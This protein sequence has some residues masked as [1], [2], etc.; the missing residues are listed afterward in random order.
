MD[1]SL[2]QVRAFLTVARV[3]S[4]TQAA[5]ILNVTQPA[6]T[7]QIRR[8]EETLGVKLFDRDTRTV[9]L[10]RVARDL[11]PLF[12]RT[13]QD[14]EAAIGSARD[15]ASQARGVV[16]LAVLPS[17]AAG[18]LPDAIRRFREQRPNVTFD[19]KDVI[20][21]RVLGLVQSEEV[22]FGVMGGTIKALDVETVFQAEDRLHVIYPRGHPI[23]RIRKITPAALS[24]FPLILMQRDTSVRAIVD[25]SFHAAGLMA[26]A[27]CEAIYMMTAV[28]MVRAGLGLTIL[29][30][31]AREIKAEP[32]LCSRPIDDLTFSRPISIIKR[33]GRSL[34][35]LSESFLQN[36]ADCLRAALAPQSEGRCGPTIP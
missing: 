21:G 30:G 9:E 33:S 10:T 12:E 24:A 22:D 7:M 27:T 1:V 13:L 16:R 2:R 4:F 29:P 5:S 34:P 32:G 17:V 14:L 31:S 8:L 6:L 15:V 35:P 20:A 23:G 19:L 25:A 3:R 26:R 18:V 28:G 36:L 11:L